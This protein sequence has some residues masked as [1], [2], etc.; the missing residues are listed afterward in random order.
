[1]HYSLLRISSAR[2]LSRGPLRNIHLTGGALDLEAGRQAG[3]GPREEG[4]AGAG[5]LGGV[6]LRRGC[7]VEGAGGCW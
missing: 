6:V 7:R 5:G 4:K 2:L 1:M 3:L